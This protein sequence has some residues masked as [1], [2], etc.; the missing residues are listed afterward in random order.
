MNILVCLKYVRDVTADRHF[1]DDHS[2]IALSS[3]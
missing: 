3:T 2:A 1:E